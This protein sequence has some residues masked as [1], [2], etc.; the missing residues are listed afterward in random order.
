MPYSDLHLKRFNYL[1]GE[2]DAVYHDISLKLG[3]SDSISK[4]LYAI[5]DCGDRCSLS[6]ICHQTGL[7][8]Q[9]VNS[10]IRKLE[11]E[12]IIYLE[13]MDGKA[14]EVCLT[15]SGKVFSARTARRILDL[16]NEIL[17]SWPPEAVAQYL[18]LT[19]QFLLALRE[20]AESL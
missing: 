18:A 19:E 20:K 15:P 5:C 13:A 12:G 2:M 4:I 16:E 17:A 8:K 14:K 1:L 10:A 6:R 3:L 9:T 11:S 7:S